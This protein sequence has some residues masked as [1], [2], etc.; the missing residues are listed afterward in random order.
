MK[1][2]TLLRTTTGAVSEDGRPLYSAS[3]S[4]FVFL[5]IASG[6]S[7]PSLKSMVTIESGYGLGFLKL[8][9]GGFRE[10]R[11]HQYPPLL[12]G[13]GLPVQPSFNSARYGH[14]CQAMDFAQLQGG[15]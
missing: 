15:F 1:V 9:R 6:E 12:G 14:F 2:S 7:P 4:S 13:C 3:P 10:P 5:G 8:R 11:G